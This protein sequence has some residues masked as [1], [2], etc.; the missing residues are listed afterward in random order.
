MS[1]YLNNLSRKNIL[2]AIPVHNE[3][4]FVDDILTAVSEYHSDILV[5]NDGSDDGTDKL[6]K[7]HKSIKIIVHKTNEGYGKS[8]IDAFEFAKSEGYSWIITMDCDYQHE[9]QHIPQFFREIEKDN[10]DIISGSRYLCC[11]NTENV[12]ADRLRINRYITAL[13]NSALKMDITDA[14]C[15]FKAYRIATLKKLK[16]T[17]KGYGL[18]LQLWIQAAF[19]KFRITEIPVPLIYHDPKRNF[20]GQLEIPQYRMQY[21]MDVI[22]KELVKYGC[23]DAEKLIRSGRR[24]LHTHKT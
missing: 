19:A 15:G 16:L 13:L 8:L 22:E 9:P 6:L 18:P 5:V 24:K 4:R 11:E 20:A 21:Y 1:I 17:E 12:P 3:A 14:F 2:I 23:K 10:A 7:R